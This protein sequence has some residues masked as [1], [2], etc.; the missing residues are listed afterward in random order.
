MKKC[1]FCNKNK[2]LKKFE[3]FFPPQGETRYSLKLKKYHRFFLKCNYCHH[4]YSTLKFSLKDF[5][6]SEYNRATYSGNLK[7]NFLKIKKLPNK[8]SDNFF[9]VKR[10]KSF[11]DKT[12][13]ISKK[14]KLL[15]I[16]SGLGVFPYFISKKNFDCTALDPDKNS[17]RHI[18]NYLRIKT[19]YG[20][21]FKKKI[22]TKFDIITLNK[23]IEHVKNPGKMIKKA[24]NCLSKNG[25]IYIEV[26]DAKAASKKGKNR[27]EFY[28][29]HLHVFSKKSLN[30]LIKKI[31]MKVLKIKEINEPSGKFTIFAFCQKKI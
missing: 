25:L 3:Y 16:G 11:V 31:G 24:K 7:R 8:K 9:R 29:D 27:E 20:D 4:W 23:V 12:L 10:I 19:I 26:P 5:Y 18:R 21:F 6:S 22:S 30:I 28:I 14:K 13:G 2:F 1:S 17:C 15:D